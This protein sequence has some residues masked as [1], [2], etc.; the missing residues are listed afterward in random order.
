MV[1]RGDPEGRE[2]LA[3][4]VKDGRVVAGMNANLWDAADGVRELVERAAPVADIPAEVAAL[5]TA[6]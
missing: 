3:F 1:L 4:W 2:F 5:S 6:A